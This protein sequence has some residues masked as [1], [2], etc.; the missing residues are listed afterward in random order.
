MATRGMLRALAKRT[1]SQFSVSN[2]I[3]RSIST[4]VLAEHEGGSV[5]APSVSAVEAAKLLGEEN[6]ITMLLAGSG[7]SLQEAAEH[8]ASCHPSVS[9]VLVADSDAFAYPLAEPWAK[10]VHLVQQRDDYSHVVAASSSFG[11]N[12]LPRAAALLDVSPITDVTDISGSH[13]FVRPIYAGNALCTVRYSGTTPCMLTI[14]ATSFPVTP[15]SADSKSN[16]ASISQVDLSTFDKDSIGKSRY[17]KLTSEDTERP[18]LGNARIVVTGGRGL[19]S[20]D[21]FK[22][23]EKLAEKLGAAVGATRAAVDA[24]FV[25][26][27]L[28][29]GQT[30][31]IVAPEL[32]L[33]FG[34]SGAIQHIA[35]MRD[36]K[37]IVAVNKDAD[38][39]IFQVADYGLVGDLFEVIPE[40]L[41][42][43]PEKK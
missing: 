18:D 15:D 32:Y 35:G 14:R 9:Q 3:S 21:N 13:Q 24:S 29:V 41:E 22:M 1:L 5:K 7:S 2:S 19:K 36:S 6:S 4:L 23:L 27:E 8:A 28:Q 39:P 37:I 10:L 33:A 16:V 20:A 26:N 11:K 30:G 25:P 17:V 31:K 42:K 40:L 12:I 38:A 34:V 43:L